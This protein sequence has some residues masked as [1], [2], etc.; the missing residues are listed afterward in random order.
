MAKRVVTSKSKTS[1]K[2]SSEPKAKAS[3][4]VKAK[5][6]A[7]VLVVPAPEDTV[8]SV[9]PPTDCCDNLNIN[10][11]PHPVFS[12]ELNSHRWG[13]ILFCGDVSDEHSAFRNTL[14]LIRTALSQCLLINPGNIKVLYN[15]PDPSSGADLPVD[16][17]AT[18]D[19]LSR[20][21][22]E[23]D[24]KYDVLFLVLLGHGAAKTTEDDPGLVCARKTNGTPPA[25]MTFARSCGHTFSCESISLQQVSD[26]DHLVPD[27]L[28]HRE[29]SALLSGLSN[30]VCHLI[31]HCC[32]S[33]VFADSARSGLV[34][35]RRSRLCGS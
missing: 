11:W 22:Q 9:P 15:G 14:K 17:P 6:N 29:L 30:C 1:G 32:D 24:S 12:D 28:T 21:L 33:G 16:G 34:G 18:E 35:W 8:V 2:S 3:R 25:Q 5:P 7:T 27:I 4:K 19:D 26:Q 31:V 13:A 20:L 10:E 23:A